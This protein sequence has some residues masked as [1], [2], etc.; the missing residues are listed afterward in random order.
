[1]CCDNQDLLLQCSPWVITSSAMLCKV[2][3][4]EI[5][6]VINL[7]G[8]PCDMNHMFPLSIQLY[9]QIRSNCCTQGQS[10]GLQASGAEPKFSF[11][12]SVSGCS[13]VQENRR[14]CGWAK[15]ISHYSNCS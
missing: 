13:M 11:V 5:L 6:P 7:I 1:M 12:I 15:C 14:T 8:P 2:N 4:C 10:E 9:S 3:T